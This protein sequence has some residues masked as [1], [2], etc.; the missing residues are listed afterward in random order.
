MKIFIIKKNASNYYIMDLKDIKFF[1]KKYSSFISNFENFINNDR[2]VYLL[3][4]KHFIDK[5]KGINLTRKY[6]EMVVL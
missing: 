3:K 6:L 4:S 5:I 2:V 1:S